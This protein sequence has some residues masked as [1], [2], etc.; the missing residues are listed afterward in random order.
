MALETMFEK[1]QLTNDKH[2][3]IQGLPSTIEKQFAKINFCK[4]VTPLL[5]SRRIDFALVFA[6][7]RK[8]LTDI[9][10]D[11]VPALQENAKFWVAYPKP[12]A[13]IASD[14]CRDQNW[15]MISY[16]GYE[17]ECTVVLDNVWHAIKFKKAAAIEAKIPAS[18][19][20][21]AVTA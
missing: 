13:K 7:S 18:T 12:A 6:V 20:R 15:D 8:Q 5:R 14:L 1:L 11:V 19:R 16:H 3:L 2:L 21:T 10:D 4:S 17:T 9:V